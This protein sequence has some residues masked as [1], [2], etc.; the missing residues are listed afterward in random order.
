MFGVNTLYPS[1][2]PVH[3]FDLKQRFFFYACVEES[4][5]CF[6]VKIDEENARTALRIPNKIGLK[7][8]KYNKLSER[9]KIE[10]L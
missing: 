5:N 10:F 3:K 8:A 4:K 6:Q 1:K 9:I 2:F 7:K